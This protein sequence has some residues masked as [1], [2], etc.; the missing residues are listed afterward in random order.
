VLLPDVLVKAKSE[1]ND[2]ARMI[3]RFDESHARKLW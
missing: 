2:L 3:Q 1:Q